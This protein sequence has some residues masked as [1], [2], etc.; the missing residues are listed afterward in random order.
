MI[1]AGHPKDIE[2]PEALVTAED[3]LKSV[4]EGVPHM[5]LP[6]YIGGRNDYG[7]RWIGTLDPGLKET[8]PNPVIVPVRFQFLK[9]IPFGQ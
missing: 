2:P 6:G 3:I 9:N 8:F 1:G 4:V 5:E 7:K